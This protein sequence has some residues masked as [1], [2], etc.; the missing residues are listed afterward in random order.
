MPSRAKQKRAT[1]KVWDDING[2][3]DGKGEDTR[4]RRKIKPS[5]LSGK[6][7][8]WRHTFVT[9]ELNEFDGITELTEFLGEVFWDRKTGK[10]EIHE[11]DNLI[12]SSSSTSC[13]HV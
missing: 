2:A 8:G 4:K 13:F 9:K 12:S 1:R 5:P 7:S 6:V 10:N 11:E 3:K